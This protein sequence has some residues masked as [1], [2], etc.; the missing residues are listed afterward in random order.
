M[1]PNTKY[2]VLYI[3][4]QILII[5]AKQDNWN[6]NE[7]GEGCV[8]FLNRE[9]L[10]SFLDD[11]IQPQEI[12][13]KCREMDADY[14]YEE[15]PEIMCQQDIENLERASGGFHDARIAKE[16]LLNDGT[17]YL[18]FDGTWGCEIEMW[19]WGDLEYDTSSRNP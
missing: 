4:P 18:R 12:L 10:D 8:N 19:F 7:D 17:L 2:I 16:E 5:D 3:I 15:I 14:I 11:E 6:E 9:L 13:D 1:V